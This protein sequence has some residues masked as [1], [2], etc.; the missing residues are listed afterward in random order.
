MAVLVT[1]SWINDTKCSVDHKVARIQKNN[2]ETKN[3]N[4]EY[5]QIDNPV[6]K[7]WIYSTDGS[8]SLLKESKGNI[9][10][11]NHCIYDWTSWMQSTQHLNGC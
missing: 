6:K 9:S 1:A 5:N 10:F 2:L 4:S 3:N 8:I 11:T 7:S